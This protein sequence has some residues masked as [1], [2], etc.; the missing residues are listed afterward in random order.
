MPKEI[1]K[2]QEKQREYE[3]WKRER[4]EKAA[5]DERRRRLLK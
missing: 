2:Q 1:R 4:V 5:A 3:E